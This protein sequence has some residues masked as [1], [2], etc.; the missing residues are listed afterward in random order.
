MES[1]AFHSRSG[2]FCHITQTD[3]TLPNHPRCKT[4]RRKFNKNKQILHM[5][6]TVAF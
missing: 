5:T 2:T 6:Q 1:R 3:A 4:S